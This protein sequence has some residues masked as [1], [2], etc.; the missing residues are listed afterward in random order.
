MPFNE[1]DQQL[2]THIKKKVE[3]FAAG[4]EPVPGLDEFDGIED[5]QRSFSNGL[6]ATA[7]NIKNLVASKSP[8]LD[9]KSIAN[10]MSQA[11]FFV[12]VLDDVAAAKAGK[13][14]QEKQVCP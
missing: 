8:R 1:D 10:Y 7:Q 13:I 11:S 9:E 6:E 12:S 3:K 4:A 5:I 2:A 14:G